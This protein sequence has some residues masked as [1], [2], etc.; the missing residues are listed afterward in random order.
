MPLGD[1][2]TRVE[3]IEGLVPPSVELWVK[4]E[5]ESAAN[6]GGNKVRKLE[7]L[8][9]DAR[10]RGLR[11]LSTFGGT[12]SHHVAATA[13]HG[14]AAGFEVEATLVPQPNDAHVRELLLAEQA[15]GARLAGADG[16][17]GVI[18]AR[19]RAGRCGA[20]WLAGG[21]SSA[22]GTLGWV[23]GGFEI[24]E[25]TDS[26]VLPWP[27]VI[28]AAL[29]S[30]GTIA[31]L[32]W[33]L[34]APRPIELV[35]VSVVGGVVGRVACGALAVRHLTARVDRLL[36]PL[37]PAPPGER[38]RLR[39]DRRFL[40]AGYGHPSASSMAATREAAERGLSLDPIYT[41]KVMAALLTDARRG[42]LDGKR[43]L[44]LHSFSTVSL[45]SLIAR[46][47]GPSALPPRLRTLFE[48]R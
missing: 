33:S 19:L 35:G 16:Y 27:D 47:P 24:L 46:A 39:I 45:D 38:P 40:G 37:G 30:A 31:G 8:L 4:R 13:I 28:Y 11:R 25:Q 43:V 17:L 42:R 29:G 41:G 15:V 3:R 44:F 20:A 36:A 26:G 21:G 2:P 12:G 10:A 5:D 9:G 7:F 18:P 1:F 32:W 14:R 6:Y 22:I 23:S 48:A 34:R